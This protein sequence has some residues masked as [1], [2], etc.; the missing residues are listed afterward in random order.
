MA[1]MLVSTPQN[2]AARRAAITPEVIKDQFLDDLRIHLAMNDG[3]DDLPDATAIAVGVLIRE[4]VNGS[5]KS[6]NAATRRLARISPMWLKIVRKEFDATLRMR[7]GSVRDIPM[8]GK[9]VRAKRQR[10]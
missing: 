2:R 9:R 4:M 5:T 3:F 8:P 6:M 7:H 10:R 1:T